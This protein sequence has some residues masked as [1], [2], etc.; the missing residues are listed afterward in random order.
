MENR[1]RLIS[2]QV[3]FAG[4]DSLIPFPEQYIRISR[5]AVYIGCSSVNDIPVGL[6]PVKAGGFLTAVT[7]SQDGF[8]CTPSY[9]FPFVQS[10]SPVV[11]YSS[12]HVRGL[13]KVQYYH[14][15]LENEVI[16]P[17]V[18]ELHFL[19]LI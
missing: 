8:V 3:A 16:P 19:E 12:L 2:V 11:D 5:P 15:D 10:P 1:Y 14:W 4:G 17:A 7:V 6:V 13:L 9:L 18:L